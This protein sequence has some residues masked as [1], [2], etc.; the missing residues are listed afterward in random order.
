MWAGMSKASGFGMCLCPLL[1]ACWVL[2]EFLSLSPSF[3]F[4]PFLFAA[5]GWLK[6]FN[7]RKSQKHKCLLWDDVTLWIPW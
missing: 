3:V 5:E 4:Y 1:T 7:V 2:L 6:L